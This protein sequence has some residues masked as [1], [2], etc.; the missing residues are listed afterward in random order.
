MRVENGKKSERRMFEFMKRT[1]KATGG[2]G[3]GGGG[4]G[5][6]GC[7]KPLPNGLQGKAPENFEF[8]VSKTLNSGT[9]GNHF[10]DIN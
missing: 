6:G 3:G 10:V 9:S 2:L 1:K 5:A 7:C 8:S 4:L